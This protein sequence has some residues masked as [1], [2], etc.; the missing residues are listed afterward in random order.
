MPTDVHITT[1]LIW[2]CTLVLV[3]MNALFIT[4]AWRFIKRDLFRQM[5]WDET[6]Q[7]DLVS[8]EIHSTHPT[9][10]LS[11]TPISHRISRS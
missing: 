8:F 2:T 4:I 6:Q 7:V 9:L 5:R 10:H 11:H 1:S 3:L